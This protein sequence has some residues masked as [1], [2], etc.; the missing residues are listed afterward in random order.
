MKLVKSFEV[1]YFRAS[2][3]ITPCVLWAC[4]Y[5]FANLKVGAYIEV[6]EAS[7]EY[8]EYICITKQIA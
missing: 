2:R 4:I 5:V 7:F 6:Q 8:K 3:N 1:L